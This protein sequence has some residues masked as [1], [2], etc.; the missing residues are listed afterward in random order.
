MRML[1]ALPNR[2]SVAKLALLLV[3]AGAGQRP[4]DLGTWS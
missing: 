2:L 1:I 4:V 3:V